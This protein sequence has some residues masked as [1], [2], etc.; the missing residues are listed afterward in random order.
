MFQ[1]GGNAAGLRRER[2]PQ[3]T[4]FHLPFRYRT[5][6][7]GGGRWAT[8]SA[9]RW[10]LGQRVQLPIEARFFR[11]F[12]SSRHKQ[13]DDRSRFVSVTPASRRT[14]PT[15]TYGPAKRTLPEVDGQD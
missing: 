14:C 4:A 12:A 11:D 7:K 2:T 9:A 3:D 1:E 10:S 8:L 6:F 5:A 15:R 13:G